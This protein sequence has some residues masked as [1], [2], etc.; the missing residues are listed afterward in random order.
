MKLSSLLANDDGPGDPNARAPADAEVPMLRSRSHV[1]FISH[2]APPASSSFMASSTSP[3]VLPS[4]MVK[5]RLVTASFASLRPRE[6]RP[7]TTLMIAMRLEASTPKV[8]SICLTSSEASRSC[9]WK[10]TGVGGSA[11][12]R[13]DFQG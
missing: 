8:S 13:N 5:G 10:G 1:Y 3:L 11:P 9:G 6:V 4:R 12:T 2:L 7:R